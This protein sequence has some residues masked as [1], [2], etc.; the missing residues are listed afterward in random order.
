MRTMDIAVLIGLGVVDAHD[1]VGKHAVDSE[2][3][4]AIGREHRIEVCAYRLIVRALG[5]THAVVE[6]VAERTVSHLVGRNRGNILSLLAYVRFFVAVGND[7]RFAIECLHAVNTCN[8]ADI[9]AVHDLCIAAKPS[10][11]GCAFA[12]SKDCSGVVAVGYS[13]CSLAAHVHTDDTSHIHLGSGNKGFVATV[14]DDY[15]STASRSVCNY[16]RMMETKSLRQCL[17]YGNKRFVFLYIALKDFISYR[18]STGCHQQAEKYLWITM[19]TVFGK[20]TTS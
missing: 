14:F 3:L 1:V 12:S 7:C 20:A 18:I 19:L 2:H 17:Y 15:Q 6:H 5:A 8:L 10:T 4:A 16:H 11:E 9:V 13:E